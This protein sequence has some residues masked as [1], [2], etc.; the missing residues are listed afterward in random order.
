MQMALNVLERMQGSRSRQ[1]SDLTAA[2][3]ALVVAAYHNADGQIW[4][5]QRQLHVAQQDI[6]DMVEAVCWSLQSVKV[7][8]SELGG[9]WQCLPWHRLVPTCVA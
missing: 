2:E 6:L 7:L 9:I 8:S 5:P 1:G 4:P 3:D